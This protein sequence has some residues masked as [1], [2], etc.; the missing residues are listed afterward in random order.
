[1]NVINKSSPVAS[2][3]SANA[4][5]G[6]SDAE[7]IGWRVRIASANAGTVEGTIRVLEGPT[8]SLSDAIISYSN[9]HYRFLS[10]LDIEKEDISNLSV[11][12][13]SSVSPNA[14]SVSSFNAS[15]MIQHEVLSNQEANQ[16]VSIE[17]KMEF[18]EPKI[19]CAEQ[20]MAESKMESAEQH[21]PVVA[22]EDYPLV[23]VVYSHK[24][25]K[26]PSKEKPS[27]NPN[28]AAPWASSDI[29]AIKNEEFDIQASLAKFDKQGEFESLKKATGADI[30]LSSTSVDP[31]ALFRSMTLAESAKSSEPEPKSTAAITKQE[32]SISAK[33]K[34]GKIAKAKKEEKTQLAAPNAAEFDYQPL[35]IINYASSSHGLPLEAMCE[36]GGRE[37]A[38]FLL[39]GLMANQERASFIINASSPTFYSECCLAAIRHL[40][41]R[42][43]P[44][45]LFLVSLPVTLTA[46]ED[47]VAQSR[48]PLLLARID[49]VT[50]QGAV[51]CNRIKEALLTSRVIIDASAGALGA[52]IDAV[53]NRLVT[54]EKTLYAIA[55]KTSFYPQLVAALLFF[56][57]VEECEKHFTG[58][59]GALF[60][61]GLPRGVYDAYGIRYPFIESFTTH[62]T[63]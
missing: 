13:S 62:L 16:E 60:D 15:Q 27:G 52:K 4:L 41:N 51:R 50:K 23:E 3:S 57:L 12:A 53:V 26:Q 39:P 48:V 63:M 29:Q 36:F 38:A 31:M 42:N 10:L 34:K 32:E 17:A 11:I 5:V 9:G 28:T 24:K 37:L 2:S 61:I 14:S 47:A 6:A 1:M 45:S 54:P 58:K 49:A 43:I 20:K 19:E 21:Y 25:E 8:I 44:I 56:G 40:L 35:S 59:D 30:A 33:T 22:E 7:F 46:S 18:V 55:G